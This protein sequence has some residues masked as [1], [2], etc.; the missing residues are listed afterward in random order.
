MDLDQG[1][2]C[3]SRVED[4]SL[5]NLNA[6]LASIRSS[7]ALNSICDGVDMRLLP[8]FLEEAEALCP[9]I[10][11]CLRELR[12]EFRYEPRL[13]NRLLHTLK[14]SA[15]MT[16]VMQVGDIAHAMEGLLI[17]G[18]VLPES[19][20]QDVLESHFCQISGILDVLRQFFLDKS[21]R[22]DVYGLQEN[23]SLPELERESLALLSER[24]HCTVRSTADELRKQVNLELMISDVGPDALE[25]LTEPLEHLLRNAVVHGLEDETSRRCA[26]KENTGNIFLGISRLNN[27]IVCVVSDDGRG[28]N[29]HA[30][31]T[32]AISRGLLNDA[33]DAVSAD[34]LAKL[35]FIP[36]ISTASEVTQ[37]AGRG[38]GMDVVNSKISALGG[39]VSVSSEPGRGTR[40]T[41]YLPSEILMPNCEPI[42]SQLQCRHD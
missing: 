20:L 9:A 36:G 29:L 40:F 30:L 41:M 21:E 8:L 15:R 27:E 33:D 37:L 12:D 32:K 18:G 7:D 31:H 42:I 38:I 39:H 23:L 5:L 13:L 19:E 6:R 16:G 2:V 3:A 22:I 10:L 25:Q 28:L 11:A 4:A 24:L 35:I 17:A 34:Q 26:G 1:I 14:G